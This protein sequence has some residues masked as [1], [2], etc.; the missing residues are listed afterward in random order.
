MQAYII[1]DTLYFSFFIRRHLPEK[2]VGIGADNDMKAQLDLEVNTKLV[3]V[4]ENLG[5]HRI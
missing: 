1:I 2:E 4:M 5:G 3:L